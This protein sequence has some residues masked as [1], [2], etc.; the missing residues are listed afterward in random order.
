MQYSWDSKI[1]FSKLL[2][3][4][5]NISLFVLLIFLSLYFIIIL[6]HFCFHSEINTSD[7][8]KWQLRLKSL[9]L[10]SSFLIIHIIALVAVFINSKC[11]VIF[12]SQELWNIKAHQL[13]SF[14]WWVNHSVSGIRGHKCIWHL[15]GKLF[16]FWYVFFIFPIP[17]YLLIKF[18]VL[19]N[20]NLYKDS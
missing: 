5:A 11:W 12:S 20:K 3:S 10:L 9:P 6:W 7:L 2:Q 4:L 15:L 1:S 16:K 17:N 8:I 13:H 19:E 14:S 18:E